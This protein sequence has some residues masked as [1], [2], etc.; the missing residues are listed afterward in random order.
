MACAGCN[1][2]ERIIQ[3]LLD[4]AAD[5]GAMALP[6]QVTIPARIAE[7]AVG[8]RLDTGVDALGSFLRNYE[9]RDDLLPKKR[10]RK[11]SAYQREFGRQMKKLKKK[12][13]RTAAK[14]LMKRAHTATKKARRK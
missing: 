8:D 12:H 5:A 3:I 4:L 11:V 7:R 9:V 10:K 14:T 1:R 13:P 2:R 6:P